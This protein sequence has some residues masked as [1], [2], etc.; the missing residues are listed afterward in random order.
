MTERTYYVVTTVNARQVPG[1]TVRAQDQWHAMAIAAYLTRQINP[2]V[3]LGDPINDS[4]N[5][6]HYLSRYLTTEAGERTG[7]IAITL[8]TGSTEEKAA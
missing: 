4:A 6:N 5:P 8:A 3:S 2:A 1:Y 7:S